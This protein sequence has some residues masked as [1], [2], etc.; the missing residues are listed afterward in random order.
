MATWLCINQCGACCHLD[1]AE[2]PNL[3]EYLSPEELE[4]YL[5]MVGEDGWCINFDPTTRT[6]RIYAERP[7][8]CRVTPESF[9]D[10]FGIAPEELNDFAIDCCH[11][12]ISG[13]YSEHSPEKNRFDHAIE[14]KAGT[15]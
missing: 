14:D 15:V 11:Q 9:Q 3:D 1:P 13:V 4:L 5:G 6:C 10:L 8:F 12:Q 2:R 7:R